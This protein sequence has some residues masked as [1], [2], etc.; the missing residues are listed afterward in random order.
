MTET[1][2]AIPQ[3]DTK[4]GKLK[5]LTLQ[6]RLELATKTKKKL[7]QGS[8]V[9]KGTSSF[10]P[11]DTSDT[12]IQGAN[13]FAVSEFPSP[14]VSESVQTSACEELINNEQAIE[15]PIGNL[16]DTDK[17]RNTETL[18]S[19]EKESLSK[20]ENSIENIKT[21]VE[22]PQDSACNKSETPETKVEPIKHNKSSS[23]NQAQAPAQVKAADIHASDNEHF[24]SNQTASKI[25]QEHEKEVWL[26]KKEIE[27]LN[28][29]VESKSKE[30]LSLKNSNVPANVEKKLQEKENIIQQL[31]REGQELSSKEVKQ[32][33]RIRGLIAQNKELEISLKNYAQKNE[34]SLLKIGEIEDAI[35]LHNYKSLDQ[36]LDAMAKNSQRIS[37]LQTAVQREKKLNWEGKYKELQ[38]LYETVLEELRL[39]RKD[40]SEKAVQFEL[41]Q[42]LSQLELKSKD[43][44]ISKLNQEIINTKDE[45]SVEL[46]RL[47]SKIEQLRSEN[48]SFLKT[49]HQDIHDNDDGS[50][51]K[52]IDYQDYA[53]L[54]SSNQQ[55]QEQFL[56]SQEN[57]R[58]IELDLRYKLEKLD[59]TLEVLKKAKAKASVELSKAMSQLSEQTQQVAILKKEVSRLS[60][61]DADNS[62]KLN[63]KTNE[64]NDLEEELKKLEGI[65]NAEKA[66]YEMKIQT[67]LESIATL[68]NPPSFPPSAS[69]ESI[70]MQSRKHSLDQ[71]HTM[72]SDLRP[73]MRVH[74]LNSL[75]FQL[76]PNLTPN[77]PLVGWE[78]EEFS[79]SQLDY[80]QEVANFNTTNFGNSEIYPQDAAD[81]GSDVTPARGNSGATKN[82]QIISKM[83]S[84]IRRLEMD[85]LSLKEEN[86]ELSRDKEQ[87]QQEILGLMQVEATVK[88]LTEKTEQ[89]Q[90]ELQ[91]KDQNQE[92]LLQVIGEKSERVE[93]LQ[94]DVEDLKDLMRQQVQQMIEMQSQTPN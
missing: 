34:Q 38:K 19:K 74:S 84:N 36:L 2:S 22:E 69:S 3:N 90:K 50:V 16:A 46:S 60:E 72:K 27:R 15:L 64:C 45:A 77:T 31:M 25:T 54:S 68:Q 66:N 58:T 76:N 56:L 67:L 61:L 7:S 43:K 63:M 18:H 10:V 33:E 71:Y 40:S 35:K 73:A 83:S 65:Y 78:E 8:A 11:S 59:S 57:W 79:P 44:I 13:A 89:L 29:L 51:S 28:G 82:I 53:K 81:S 26:L 75:N 85:I 14:L 92:T 49:N 41:L 88:E 39:S 80:S 30:I 4:T 20:E 12:P 87:A 94:A 5:R 17:K 37:E 86:E 24:V 32:N 21:L 91:E 42:N 70:V 55:L 48:E 9:D 47:E 1:E 52:K 62:F 6:E 23:I 93:E